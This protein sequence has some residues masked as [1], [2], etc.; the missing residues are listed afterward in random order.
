MAVYDRLCVNRN[1]SG[2]FLRILGMHDSK[3]KPQIIKNVPVSAFP[4]A[5][6][7]EKVLF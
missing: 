7:H 3:W 2:S 1:R 6:D 4:W 5:R